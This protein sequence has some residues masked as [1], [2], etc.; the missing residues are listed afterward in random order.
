[1]R[2]AHRWKETGFG[3]LQGT[4]LGPILFNILRRNLYLGVDNTD[5]ANCADDNNIY[6]TGDCMN[7]LFRGRNV[8]KCFSSII[9]VINLNQLRL[10]QGREKTFALHLIF[11]IIY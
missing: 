10:V 3:L 6:D 1:M 9:L 2:I 4:T 11:F 8:Q 5:F 7:Y